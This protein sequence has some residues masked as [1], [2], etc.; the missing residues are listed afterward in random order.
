MK[1]LLKYIIFFIFVF[2]ISTS[3]ANE[4]SFEFLDDDAQEQKD[5][6]F[7]YVVN[8]PHPL[9]IR[10][11][12]KNTDGF[13]SKMMLLGNY[14]NL[15][16]PGD[17]I[18]ID[19]SE[20]VAQ[21][22]PE[23]DTQD[24]YDRM[25]AIKQSV[26]IYRW[27]IKKYDE[28]KEKIL[29][30]KEKPI[31]VEDDEYAQIDTY[32]YISTP[33][34]QFGILYDF[35]K[36]VPYSNNPRDI[37]SVRAKKQREA[38]AKKHK[39]NFD[40]FKSMV[41]KIEFSKIYRYGIDLPNP[42]VGNAGIGSWI[43][44]D[45]FKVRLMSELGEFFDMSEIIGGVHVITPNHRFILGSNLFPNLEKPRFEV[46]DSE[47]IAQFEVLY[48]IAEKY[49]SDY[50]IGAYQGDFLFPFKIIPQEESQPIFLQ[51]KVQLTHC[52][53][54]FSC[55]TIEF[56]PELEIDAGEINNLNSF[57][58]F[59]RQGY[60]HL[61]QKENEQ[62][63]LENV[64]VRLAE[65]KPDVE[66]I[67]LTYDN[68]GGSLKN[69]RVF[70]EDDQF[71]R[72]LNPAITINKNKIYVTVIPQNNQDKLFNSTIKVRTQF[73]PYEA[74]ENDV[75]LSKITT[76]TS[77]FEVK[78]STYLWCAFLAGL[79]MILT[80]IGW[81][82]LIAIFK[83]K[84]VNKNLKPM[85][86]LFCGI[87]TSAVL[88]LI[89]LS[90]LI[91]NDV[92]LYWG[93]QY[94][95]ITCIIA[96]IMALFLIKNWCFQPYSFAKVFKQKQIFL[97]SLMLF[98]SAPLS[99]AFFLKDA[100]SVVYISSL[101][102]LTGVI[103]LF[104]LGLCIIYTISLSVLPKLALQIQKTLD[105]I[106]VGAFYLQIL[107]LII[108]IFMQFPT[109]CGLK[110]SLIILIAYLLFNFIFSIETALLATD[111]TKNQKRNT[112]FVLTFFLIVISLMTIKFQPDCPVPVHSENIPLQEIE[113][114]IQ[115]GKNVIVMV[116]A[117]W[118][119]SCRLDKI[120]T[121]NSSNMRQWQRLY[122]TEFVTVNVSRPN[123]E[124]IE[125][126]T[127]FNRSAPPLYVLY[128]FQIQNGL[129]FTDW[130]NSNNVVRTLQNFS[131]NR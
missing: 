116:E 54:Q 26:Q 14:F 69:V 120:T 126:L 98:F 4:I 77:N 82:V 100:F 112:E 5:A 81:L 96:S 76:N 29:M 17:K 51:L 131:I 103:L 53:S 75:T 92:F 18:K 109:N 21:I 13:L 36:I 121:F 48:P 39:T 113:N 122:N 107:A 97:L 2:N 11:Q 89:F 64:S 8:L 79:F 35:K 128:N 23:L 123:R 62:F 56:H 59:I 94:Q 9:L 87:L 83:I 86:Q 50:M 41:H 67:F 60:Y 15:R 117:D 7:N 106:T 125:Y 119:L 66:Q 72:F 110:L 95:S 38:S 101:P 31:I 27:G 65:N 45:G 111:L 30:P 93:M 33:D 127:K 63:A 16:Y 68:D 40:Q 88:S 118:C 108:I 105:M 47:N 37:E 19:F 61:P 42:I 58:N 43:E 55:E 34:D 74:L 71:T 32:E 46:L 80:P 52:D 90:L 1:N 3:F 84:S 78:R 124:T 12:L 73:N 102:D 6:D 25:M 22:F 10:E 130:V 44:Q 49:I 129:A 99:F 91:K 104:A 20:D 70:V 85:V 115:Q 114:N 57:Q 28:I 24:V